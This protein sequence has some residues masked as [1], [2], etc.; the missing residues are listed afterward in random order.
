MDVSALVV[1]PR[2]IISQ[3][4]AHYEL[5]CP[6]PYDDLYIDHQAA[7]KLAKK[8]DAFE[9]RPLGLQLLYLSYQGQRREAYN[10]VWTGETLLERLNSI[11]IPITR[12][13]GRTIYRVSS[14]STLQYL[15]LQSIEWEVTYQPT[16]EYDEAM[17]EIGDYLRSMLDPDSCSH[18][19]LQQANSFT[20]GSI[21]TQSNAIMGS[22]HANSFTPG[23]IATQPNAIM[24]N[25]HAN[26]FTPLLAAMLPEM[27]GGCQRVNSFAPDPTAA[28]LEKTIGS[29]QM[30]SF[31]PLPPPE[32]ISE[33]QQMN[34]IAS[35]PMAEASEV[36]Q[37]VNSFTPISSTTL[38]ETIIESGFTTPEREQGPENPEA[39][40]SIA[41]G[42]GMI[43]QDMDVQRGGANP[44]ARTSSSRQAFPTSQ[45][46]LMETQSKKDG[47]AAQVIL[48]MFKLLVLDPIPG[49]KH[50]W[51]LSSEK[52]AIRSMTIDTSLNIGR[53]NW[54]VPEKLGR[55]FSQFH[56]DDEQGKESFHKALLMI[57]VRLWRQKVV[58]E[59]GRKKPG[60]YANDF[61][62][63]YPF[64]EGYI[65]RT[66]M[67]C[68]I[69]V[70]CGHPCILALLVRVAIRNRMTLFTL[71]DRLPISHFCHWL[72]TGKV[73]DVNHVQQDQVHKDLSWLHTNALLPLLQVA[74]QRVP[75]E[76]YL[77]DGSLSCNEDSCLRAIVPGPRQVKYTLFLSGQFTDSNW[78]IGRVLLEGKDDEATSEYS[79][80]RDK[81]TV[82]KFKLK[83]YSH[84]EHFED[85]PKFLISQTLDMDKN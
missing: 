21:A 48:H 70:A 2:K 49:S 83:S 53:N 44:N 56:R 16:E 64:P 35:V 57:A 60:N 17:R 7:L 26:S 1:G 62:K 85:P 37:Q 31:A 52:Q 75:K 54:T 43:V 82:H 38:P 33:G 22:Q 45:F 8:L 9:P 69:V 50:R 58:Y 72:A 79:I 59:N 24:G 46:T 28:M 10:L 67:V 78:A 4:T 51:S 65:R 84:I 3:T 73:S 25:Q 11:I 66:K 19:S 55:M 34:S 71:L 18:P 5:P 76:L 61:D 30:N 14:T 6:S 74:S 40:F 42:V 80:E 29:Q 68:R 41:T 47:P 63:S 81:R 12:E 15:Q 77:L 23:S 20:P 32:T 13:G 36:S 27:F 39:S